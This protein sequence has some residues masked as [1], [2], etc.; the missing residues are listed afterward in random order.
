MIKSCC[1]FI[2]AS[3]YLC[4]LL[5]TVTLVCIRKIAYQIQGKYVT[6]KNVVLV[7][8]KHSGSWPLAWRIWDLMKGTIELLFAS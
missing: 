2:L 8:G 7:L 4:S 1:G 5:I 3:E 6:F